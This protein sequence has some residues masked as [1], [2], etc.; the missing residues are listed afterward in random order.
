MKK[1]INF[2]TIQANCRHKNPTSVGVL[3]GKLDGEMCVFHFCPIW[4][5]LKDCECDNKG[6]CVI[7]GCNISLKGYCAGCQTRL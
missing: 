3:C 4:A 6:R 5:G 1:Q 2:E 7:C